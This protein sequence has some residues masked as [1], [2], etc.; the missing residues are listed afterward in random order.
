MT[1]LGSQPGQGHGI[2]VAEQP[3]VLLCHKVG[4]CNS[5]GQPAFGCHLPASPLPTHGM[6]GAVRPPDKG[7]GGSFRSKAAAAVLGG[8]TGGAGERG[9][10]YRA[11]LE[12]AFA[13]GR[14]LVG[15]QALGDVRVGH[16]QEVEVGLQL[17]AD[18]LLRQQRPAAHPTPFPHADWRIHDTAC[19][20]AH[21]KG[22]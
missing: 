21:V 12:E 9:G 6:K 17:Q 18:A 22:P 7:Q 1:A 3:A 13:E 11:H 5:S 4:W 10:N 2:V 15:E 8:P 19:S 16:L 14:V 20:H